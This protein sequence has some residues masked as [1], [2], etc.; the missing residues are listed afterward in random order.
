[1]E[2]LFLEH[3]AR[4]VC[5]GGILVMVVPYD[6]AYDCRSVLTSQFREKVVYRLTEPQATADKQ[7]VVFGFRRT[8]HERERL[9]DRAVQQADRKLRDLCVE[10]GTASGF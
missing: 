8:R 1:M 6:R 4:W 5:P 3:V 2:R 7:V 10:A 9:D